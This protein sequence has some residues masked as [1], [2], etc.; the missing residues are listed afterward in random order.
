MWLW[1]NFGVDA[2][3]VQSSFEVAKKYS[4]SIRMLRLCF[5]YVSVILYAGL[6]KDR[7]RKCGDFREGEG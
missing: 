1:E 4:E 3:W 7:E 5:G 6:G 2:G